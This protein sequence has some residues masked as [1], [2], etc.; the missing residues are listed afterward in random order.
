MQ[1]EN[2]IIFL[3][4]VLY[5]NTA[6]KRPLKMMDHH[7]EGEAKLID[8]YMCGRTSEVLMVANIS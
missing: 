6:K 1:Y 8:Y 3:C 4:S 2:M 7:C 5:R